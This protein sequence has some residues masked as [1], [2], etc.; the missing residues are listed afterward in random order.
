MMAYSRLL[1]YQV[2]LEDGALE[3]PS[4]VP[5]A[6]SVG[7]S[8]SAAVTLHVYS[9]SGASAIQGMNSILSLVGT[10]AF[11]AGVEIYGREWSFGFT[12][13]VSTGVFC[14][15]PA[16]C[17]AHAY[18]RPLPM[19]ETHLSQ[20][21]VLSLIG[22]LAKEWNGQ[23]YDLLRCN[24][25][26]FSHELC[27]RLGVGPIPRWLTSLAGAGAA[28]GDQL[29]SA[30]SGAQVLLPRPTAREAMRDVAVAAGA[31]AARKGLTERLRLCA[32][33]L[34]ACKVAS[35]ARGALGSFCKARRTYARH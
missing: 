6:A 5:P 17:E 31:G 7:P 35:Q 11:H 25:C 24:C 22:R 29:R 33:P 3:R 16:G 9:V 4:T 20:P 15:R 14:C 34:L 32:A 19:G 23:D 26:H 10:G 21:E 28:L 13:D 2:E 1:P 8:V 30:A 18:L 27:R 12:E